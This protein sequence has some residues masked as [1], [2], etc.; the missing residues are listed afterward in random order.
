MN[1]VTI[2]AWIGVVVLQPEQ[3]IRGVNFT[4]D[5]RAPARAEHILKV[6][7]DLRSVG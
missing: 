5:I 4:E 7:D 2:G 3:D 1:P 6:I